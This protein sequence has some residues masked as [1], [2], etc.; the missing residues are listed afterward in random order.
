MTGINGSDLTAPAKKFDVDAFSFAAHDEWSDRCRAVTREAPR[1]LWRHGLAARTEG[2]AT[3]CTC[4]ERA[5][6][7][8]EDAMER[9]SIGMTITAMLVGEEAEGSHWRRP[10]AA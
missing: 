10:G 5:A 4:I 2:N 8:A 3:V 1:V 6:G 7:A 9:A